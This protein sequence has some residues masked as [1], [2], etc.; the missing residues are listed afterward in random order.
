M[1]I[2]YGFVSNS[3]S[4]SFLLKLDSDIP[5]TFTVAKKMLYDKYMCY[6]Q[7]DLIDNL[8]QIIVD[9]V[10]LN[11]PIFFRSTNYDTF[12]IPLFD[13]YVFVD[14]CNNISWDSIDSNTV[15][16]TEQ[17]KDKLK[18]NGFCHDG[19]DIYDLDHIFLKKKELEY[20]LIEE[21]GFKL[22]KSSDRCK[23]CYGDKFIY[24]GKSYCFNCSHDKIS[25]I[26]KLDKIKKSLY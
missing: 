24:N 6:G 14:T 15:R 21:G 5:N 26:I 22:K 9:D 4:S 1:K 23:E 8:S 19:E 25:R 20:L 2:R 18:E 12:I 16:L 3:S 10:D 7:D 17:L 13:E 11:I